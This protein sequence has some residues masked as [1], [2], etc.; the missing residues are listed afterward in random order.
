MVVSVLTAADAAIEFGVVTSAV[1][2]MLDG[3][4]VRRMS[5]ALTPVKS[6]ASRVEKAGASNDAT[7]PAS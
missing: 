5:D 7:S 3:V 2:L 6:A 4:T 1:T